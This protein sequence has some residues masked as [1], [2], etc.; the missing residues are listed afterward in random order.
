[1]SEKS[2]SELIDEAITSGA[3]ALPVFPRAVTELRLALQ[4]E[5]RSLDAIAKQLAMDASLASQILR[6]ANS[7]FYAGLGS[8]N[9]VKDALVRLGLP[10]IVQ[11]ATLVAQKGLFAAKD[12]A[13]Q[14]YMV[15]LWQHSVA[16]ALG[17]EWLA[18]RLSFQTIAEEA[19]MA[20]LFH[21]IG[22]LLLL[23]CLEDLAAKDL[24]LNL[25]ADLQREL[26]IRQHE[27]KGA[28]LLQEWNLP[29]TYRKVAA[30]HHQPAT[31]H[32]GTVELLV[33]VADMVAYK[34]GIA[35]RPQPDLVI[36]SS[37]E[38]GR[39]GLSEIMLAELEIAL[40]DSLAL[41]A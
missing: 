2:L 18:K 34:L 7:S 41:S 32:T 19:F 6:V 9:T 37:E 20:G 13:T 22:E 39:L 38:A 8:I 35:P 3:S 16:V 5:N 14:Q 24:N 31:E 30:N 4:D 17:A 1:M 10:R 36:S 25:P 26:I 11:I 12:A 28:W 33:R 29:E 23:R 15:K 27:S 21:D 40:E